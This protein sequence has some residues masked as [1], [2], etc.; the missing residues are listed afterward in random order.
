MKSDTKWVQH[1]HANKMFI[2]LTWP[3]SQQIGSITNRTNTLFDVCPAP[4][5]P[6]YYGC[7]PQTSFTDSACIIQNC[8]NVELDMLVRFKFMEF[9]KYIHET[10]SEKNI[11]LN[12]V[13]P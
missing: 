4:Y 2:T 3:M 10:F 8:Y 9:S 12:F 1:I 6:N 7:I 13:Q 11:K 5:S